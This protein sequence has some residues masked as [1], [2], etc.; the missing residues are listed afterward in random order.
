MIQGGERRVVC[1]G[2][3]HCDAE[4]LFQPGASSPGD[5][6]EGGRAVRIGIRLG[7]GAKISWI[8]WRGWFALSFSRAARAFPPF[9]NAK[10][11]GERLVPPPCPPRARLACPL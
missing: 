5:A 11:S 1:H 7:T 2:D 3:C 10:N 8:S 6:S 9:A 4:G